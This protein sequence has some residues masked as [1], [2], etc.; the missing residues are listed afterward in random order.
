ML[1][2][3]QLRHIPN[4]VA[5]VYFLPLKKNSLT[6][7]FVTIFFAWRLVLKQ[8]ILETILTILKLNKRFNKYVH[9]VKDVSFEIGQKVENVVLIFA[10]EHN[11]KALLSCYIS[12]DIVASK[13][14][15]AG[16][17]VRT[18]GNYIEGGGGGQPFFATAGGKN[19]AG[20]PEA[21]EQAVTLIS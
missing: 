2:R 10:A 3:Y 14:L 16:A 8:T 12:K 13:K 20:I 6:P 17:I 9:A 4:S 5:N 11:R 7:I 1:V 15:N 21:L 18:L 19:P